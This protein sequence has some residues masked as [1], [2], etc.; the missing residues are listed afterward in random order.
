VDEREHTVDQWK[1]LIYS[2]VVDYE[3][4]HEGETPGGN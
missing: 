1:D 3:R 4:V 2:E